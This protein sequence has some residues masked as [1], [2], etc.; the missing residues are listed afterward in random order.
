MGGIVVK[1]NL[2][3]IPE[4]LRLLS[5]TYDILNHEVA[6]YTLHQ[7]E[8]QYHLFGASCYDYIDLFSLP[9]ENA[10]LIIKRVFG[11]VSLAS[12]LRLMSDQENLYLTYQTLKR[13]NELY[14]YKKNDMIIRCCSL[15]KLDQMV[16]YHY[17]EGEYQ[18]HHFASLL[19]QDDLY[20][21]VLQFSKLQDL[22][23]LQ[24]LRRQDAMASYDELDHM[25]TIT[26]LTDGME[27]FV[28]EERIDINQVRDIAKQHETIYEEDTK[29]YQKE[30][31]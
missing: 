29:V 12:C 11:D 8:N 30:T 23:A 13:E 9:E 14:S 26:S 19:G 17:E 10:I 5:V 15:G 1:I 4:N 24:P 2:S 25:F 27:I 31:C 16:E 28:R 20:L 7:D 22:G 6:S 3:F 18:C 21:G